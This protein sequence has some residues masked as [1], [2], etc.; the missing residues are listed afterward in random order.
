MAGKRQALP[1][2]SPN[3]A[4]R[5]CAEQRRVCQALQRLKG[6]AA[7][8][9]RQADGTRGLWPEAFAARD[10][11]AKLQAATFACSKALTCQRPW[12]KPAVCQGFRGFMGLNPPQTAGFDQG[13]WPSAFASTKLL[14]VSAPGYVQPALY[15]HRSPLSLGHSSRPFGRPA[16]A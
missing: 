6:Q 12:W 4:L 3:S 2:H 9:E 8:L 13:L 5:L 11:Q 16:N 10:V 7:M 14:A 1:A 15:L